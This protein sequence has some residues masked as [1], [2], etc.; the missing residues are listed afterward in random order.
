ML[1]AVVV[2]EYGQGL[3]TTQA[4]NMKENTV[5]ESHRKAL[6]AMNGPV[7]VS[8]LVYIETPVFISPY[9]YPLQRLEYLTFVL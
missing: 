9:I 2:E 1:A 6:P 8:Y 7:K 5:M 3:A 4:L